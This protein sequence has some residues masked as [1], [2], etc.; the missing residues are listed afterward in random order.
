[1]PMPVNE[2]TPGAGPIRCDGC[3]LLSPKPPPNVVPLAPLPPKLVPAGS[4]N[5]LPSPVDP[6]D[7]FNPP[8][9]VLPEDELRERLL[10]LED[11]LL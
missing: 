10:L 6:L 8:K 7:P 3:K 5:M 2:L 4:P 1:M 9:D 11:P